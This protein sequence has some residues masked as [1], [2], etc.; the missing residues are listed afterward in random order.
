MSTRTSAG[1]ALHVRLAELPMFS[2][3]T[4]RELTTIAKLSTPREVAAGKVLA[5][6]GSLGKEFVIILDGTASVAV[7]GRRVTTLGPGDYFGEIA[8]LDKYRRT[9][10][11][12]AETPMVIDVVSAGDFTQLLREVP[13]LALKVMRGLAVM[14][15]EAR[16]NE[17]V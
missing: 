17:T 5:A 3:C 9:A 11:V 6:E 14:V 13:S 8:L 16:E 15:R 7:H 2:A 10:T 4:K 12:T 1:T